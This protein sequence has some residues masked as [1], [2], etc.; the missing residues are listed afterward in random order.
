MMS[1]QILQL[2]QKLP[3]RSVL[4]RYGESGWMRLISFMIT[5]ALWFFIH[6]PAFARQDPARLQE[7]FQQGVALYQSG[8]FDESL[9]A[10]ARIRDSGYES[11]PLYYNMGNCHY[12]LGRTGPAI[13]FY[14]RAR[15]FMP[16]DPDLAANLALANLAVVDRIEPAPRFWLMAVWDAFVHLFPL[17]VT[18]L[19][20]AVFFV[21]T[22]ALV[23]GMILA[24]PALRR[25]L[26]KLCWVS[27]ILLA[28]SALSWWGGAREA[29]TRVEAV[30]METKV[31]VMS[32]PVAQ[33][34]VEVFSLHEGTKVRI[35][36]MQDEWIEI[37]LPDLKV[38]WV[39]KSALEVILR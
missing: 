17:P 1:G 7:A 12:K 30:I 9:A 23:I 11:G 20:A 24:G 26:L 36:R 18:R 25:F 39:K 28:V 3:I 19:L 16:K 4:C 29:K 37:I 33:G 31:E 35:D 27:G 13:L 22:C 15:K 6:P 8:Q 5:A 21:M 34:G 32:A 2:D 10:F 14:E 38:G